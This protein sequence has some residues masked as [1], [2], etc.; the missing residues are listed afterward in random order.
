M[1]RYRMDIFREGER[2]GRRPALW[3]RHDIYALDDGAA[4]IEAEECYRDYATRLTL[5]SFPLYSGS[6]RFVG[7]FPTKVD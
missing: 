6:G 1:V 3:R 4:K 2:L 7:E 5:T